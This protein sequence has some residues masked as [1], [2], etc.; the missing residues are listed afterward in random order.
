[1]PIVATVGESHES[2]GESTVK[3]EE[4]NEDEEMN[5]EEAASNGDANPL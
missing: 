4:T 2:D 5:E 3:V 1:M